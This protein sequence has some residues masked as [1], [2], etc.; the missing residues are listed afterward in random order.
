MVADHA[1]GGDLHNP[2]LHPKMYPIIAR[3][4]GLCF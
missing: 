4:S 3:F 2:F 1:S